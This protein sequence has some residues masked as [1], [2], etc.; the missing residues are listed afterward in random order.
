MS[1]KTSDGLNNYLKKKPPPFCKLSLPVSEFWTLLRRH[2]S[3]KFQYFSSLVSRTESHSLVKG[4]GGL[5][6]RRKRQGRKKDGRL[7]NLWLSQQTISPLFS[8]WGGEKGGCKRKQRRQ[9]GR[10]SESDALSWLLS[11]GWRRGASMRAHAHLQQQGVHWASQPFQPGET[12][13]SGGH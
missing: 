13:S 1:V 2:S 5:K 6:K 4:A 11:Y 8:V 3:G 9:R 7:Y 10:S 12:S